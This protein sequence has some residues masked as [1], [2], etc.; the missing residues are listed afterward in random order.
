MQTNHNTCL[1]HEHISTVVSH[2]S[3]LEACWTFRPEEE[4][5]ERQTRTGRHQKSDSVVWKTCLERS[6]LGRGSSAAILTVV[7]NATTD[8]ERVHVK[9]QYSSRNETRSTHLVLRSTC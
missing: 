3:K 6:K 2:I 1:N 8:T 5:R 9:S 4:G 7:T